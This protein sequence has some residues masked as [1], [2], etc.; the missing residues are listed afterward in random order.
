MAKSL[1]TC[2]A[3]RRAEKQTSR[4]TKRV[5][6][7]IRWVFYLLKSVAMG[8]LKR[9]FEHRFTHVESAGNR[10]MAWAGS[11]YLRVSL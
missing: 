1:G 11:S 9:L 2:H 7:T 5:D 3:G 4:A 8:S 6:L 10:P